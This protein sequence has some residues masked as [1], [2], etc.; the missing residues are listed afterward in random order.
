[1]IV[2]L[3]I[4]MS[5]QFEDES[6]SSSS[7]KNQQKP[8]GKLTQLILSQP[9]A[10]NWF[11]KADEDSKSGNKEEEIGKTFQSKKTSQQSRELSFLAPQN[12]WAY[13]DQ[14]T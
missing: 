5:F 2:S 3:Q 6:A 7:S 8:M 10:Q 12:Y 4:E 13:F 9:F 11:F 14:L 1:M